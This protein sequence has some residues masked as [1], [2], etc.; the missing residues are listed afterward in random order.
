MRSNPTKKIEQYRVNDGP[1]GSLAEHGANGAFRIP[2]GGTILHVISSDGS[3]WKEIGLA[4]EPWE[5]VSVSLRV[6]TPN[7]EEM[8][9]I[10]K[11][12][13][14]SEET[15]IQ[16]HVPAKDHVNMHEYVLHMW[17]PIGVVIPRPPQISV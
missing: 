10:R 1:R 4:G 14:T 13:W 15:V 3:G 11:L 6:R 5:H 8:E 12:F 2:Y 7:W 16:F 17:R 9:F